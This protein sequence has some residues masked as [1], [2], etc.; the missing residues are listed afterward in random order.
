MPANALSL[1]R[2][3]GFYRNARACGLGFFPLP[4]GETGRMIQV[5]TCR[6]ISPKTAVGVARDLR[7]KAWSPVAVGRVSH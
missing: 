2:A 7:S 4:T 3:G 1:G 6:Q 5:Q